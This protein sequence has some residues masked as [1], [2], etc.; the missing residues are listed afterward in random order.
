MSSGSRRLILLAVAAL[1]A[2]CAEP[3]FRTRVPAGTPIVL[4]SIDTLR[5]D[6]LPAYG[7]S[8][9]ATPAIDALRADA[10]L[11][12]RAYSHTPL[13]LPSH[14][15][16]LTGL[17]PGEHGVRDNVGYQLDE[18]RIANGEIP[19]LPAAL[20]AHGYATGGAVSAFVL[21]GKSGVSAGFDLF[22][23]SIE[24]RTGA[25]LGGLQRP[26]SET[27]RLIRPWLEST[28]TRPLFLFFHLY[29]PHTPYEPPAE[30]S[31]YPSPYD[32]E[33]AAADAVVG[34]LVSLLRRLDLYERAVVVL[35]AD[36]GEGL[37]DHGEE[38]HGL[39]L[40]RE[41]LQVPLLLKLPERRFAGSTVG[42]PVQLIDLAPTL[43]DLVGLPRFPTWQGESLLAF[44]DANAPTRPI[45]SETFYP[46]LHFGW[47]ELASLVEGRHHLIDGPDP[48][49]FDLERD[50]A[51]R[52][53]LLA[54][55]RRIFAE[56][57]S[58][59]APFSRPLMPPGAVDEETRQAMAALGYLGSGGAPS[60]G[61]LPDPKSQ[62]PTLARLRTGFQQM[63]EKHWNEAEATFGALVAANPQMVDS[64][65]F[66]ARSRLK[67]G[68]QNEA[69]SA[70]QEAL[71]RSGGAPHVAQNVAS[72]LFDLR[73]YEEAAA[74]A[75]L[76]EASAP[77]FTHGL[78]ARIA[79]V[80]HDLASAE[81]EARL[82]MAGANERILPRITLAE[83]L[84][85][86]GQFE[87]ALAALAEA[88]A[89]YAQRRVEDADL[90]HGLHLIEGKIRADLGEAA[91]AE[92]AF[93][94]E[95]RLFPDD[96]RP[97]A[98]L[99][100]LYALLGRGEEGAAIL[101]EMVAKIS[102]AAAYAEAAKTYRAVGDDA[103]AAA[104]LRAGQRRFPG[105]SAFEELRQSGAR[106]PARTHT[107]TG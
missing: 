50:A 64:W 7:Y 46:R 41:A 85:A 79:L 82:A 35:T 17:L 51:E 23:D 52:T 27:L 91:P 30:H 55:E 89:L 42:Q 96:P 18:K 25:G 90:L 38:E 87:A 88:R 59:I 86:S 26:G 19:F 29:E 93:S 60:D 70:Y 103:G 73:R 54:S 6:R 58:R 76:A 80:D 16:M 106:S 84:H 100:L 94:E 68:K 2:A 101:R 67:L 9:V 102:T 77:S 57:R 48:E 53:N 14:V 1:L 32:G 45:Y 62:L 24:L 21:Q 81:R 98:H 4:V 75:K 83:V 61:P 28:A 36:H 15:S 107:P 74:H 37:G 31:H 71:R 56:L 3:P 99:A 44:L 43:F 78:L 22:E 49:L 40:Y 97:R 20:R 5:S 104:A 92:A 105:D 95:I 39:L 66:L 8:G 33:V 13:T 12:E 47:S 63:H 34:E 10:I 72:L 69:L 11:F 65:E